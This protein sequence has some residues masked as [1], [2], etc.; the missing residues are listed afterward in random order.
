MATE[1]ERMMMEIA[2]ALVITLQNLDKTVEGLAAEI[3]KT[4]EER[5]SEGLL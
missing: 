1:T 5:D 3:K 2:T 4:R